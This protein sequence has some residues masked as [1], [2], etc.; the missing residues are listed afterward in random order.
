MRLC[1]A[2]S[3]N[4]GSSFVCPYHAWNFHLDGTIRGI[5][6]PQ[7]YEGTRMNASNPDC[8]MKRAPRV[9]AY[10]G[11]VFASLA[12]E[13]PSLME[14]LGDARIAFDDGDPPARSPPRLPA[15]VAQ[16][17]SSVMVPVRRCRRRRA[18]RFPAGTIAQGARI[19]IQDART[20]MP[21]PALPSAASHSPR[22]ISGKKKIA[23]K[24]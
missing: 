7:G 20:S 4:T 10:R 14:F 16:P 2:I 11:F 8:S 18:A 6:L 22:V 21:S 23:R 17:K 1:G 12:P 3:G 19:R 13:G 24:K 15:T 9:E 5:P